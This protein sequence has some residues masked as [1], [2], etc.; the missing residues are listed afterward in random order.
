MTGVAV[1]IVTLLLVGVFAMFWWLVELTGGAA[2]HALS[3]CRCVQSGFVSWRESQGEMAL[4]RTPFEGGAAIDTDPE[5]AFSGESDEGFEV[6]V[7]RVRGRS[8]R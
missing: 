1:L 2:G 3:V 4:E 8:S 5:L 7:Q 6:P